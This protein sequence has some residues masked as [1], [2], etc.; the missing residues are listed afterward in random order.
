MSST[1]QRH[2]K[3]HPKK[4]WLRQH[5]NG[6]NAKQRFSWLRF[7]RQTFSKVNKLRKHYQDICDT[8][9]LTIRALL[10]ECCETPHLAAV[11]HSKA[12]QCCGLQK[13]SSC[14]GDNTTRTTREIRYVFKQGTIDMCVKDQRIQKL[15]HFTST[16]V[17]CFKRV[18]MP[19]MLPC[20][21]TWICKSCVDT[22]TAVDQ[23]CYKCIVCGH[24]PGLLK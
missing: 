9:E 17:V 22:W 4:R 3:H 14:L 23:H 2:S 24:N 15:L 19:I 10:E 5:T 16:C 11:H 1:I 8:L 18:Q 21:N 6:Y 13:L 20:C 7:G 12:V